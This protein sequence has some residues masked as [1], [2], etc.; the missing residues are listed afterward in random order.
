MYLVYTQKRIFCELG[1]ELLG[2]KKWLMTVGSA[3]LQSL[4]KRQI[5]DIKV[6]V[7]NISSLMRTY[8]L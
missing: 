8:H 4:N 3:D 1:F 2:R 5:C 6:S 7:I